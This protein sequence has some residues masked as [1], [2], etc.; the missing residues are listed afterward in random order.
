MQPNAIK[1]LGSGTIA[2]SSIQIVVP[3]GLPGAFVKA[4]L[5]VSEFAI[6]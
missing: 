2:R 6:M 5:T 4:K 3:T 1:L